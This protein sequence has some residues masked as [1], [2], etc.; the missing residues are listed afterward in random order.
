MRKKWAI[1]AL[2]VWAGAPG[3]ARAQGSGATTPPMKPA[4]AMGQSSTMTA[5]AASGSLLT[6]P[7]A[8]ALALKNHPQLQSAQYALLASNQMVR[9][10]LAAY[11]PALNGSI[12]A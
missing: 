12:T 2:L 9:E 5:T 7:E 10:Q 6:L 3:N 1:L 4:P 8:E 11:Y